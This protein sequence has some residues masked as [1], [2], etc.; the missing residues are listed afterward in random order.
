M[1]KAYTT[2]AV[3]AAAQQGVASQPLVNIKI[4]TEA[5]DTETLA[6]ADTGAMVCVAGPGLMQ[7]LGLNKG[8]L[9]TAGALK[10]VAG[11]NLNVLGSKLCKLSV[12][13]ESTYQTIH[14]IESASKCFI[15]LETCRQS[16]LYM[17]VSQSSY[18]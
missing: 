17:R 8:K 2:G 12:G 11:R 4:S 13:Q 6:V 14:F 10:D 5:G 18:K 1:K 9:A 7:E 15:S 16:S 3:I